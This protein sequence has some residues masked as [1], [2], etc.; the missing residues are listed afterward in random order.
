MSTFLTTGALQQDIVDIVASSLPLQITPLSP[1]IMRITGDTSQSIVFPNATSLQEGIHY[2]I[3]NDSNATV[4]VDDFSSS[5]LGKVERG[6][7]TT[8][9]LISNNTPAGIWGKISTGS[10]AGITSVR[11]ADFTTTVLPTG[12][13]LEVDGV[14]INNGDLVLFGNAALN[15]VYRVTGISLSLVLE[16]AGVFT[17]GSPIPSVHDA[18]LIREGKE[19]NCTIWL[20]DSGRTPPWHRIYGDLAGISVESSTSIAR[21]YP[22]A[23]NSSGTLSLVD[24]S[25]EDSSYAFCGIAARDS[26]S[27]DVA[28][29]LGAGSLFIDI[30]SAFGLTGQWGKPVFVSHAGYLTTIKPDVGVGDFVSQDFILHV[31]VTT[32]NPLT[33]TTDLILNPRIVGRLA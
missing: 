7:S 17:D 10:I 24:I 19:E 6:A 26:L 30:P 29:V 33:G 5:L 2:I 25:D 1:T 18:V 21:G 8:F 4:T 31:G 27:G 22:V 28:N 12:T 32:K 13:T 9:Y 14:T 16:E 23:I 11:A 15:R 3:I 20:Y